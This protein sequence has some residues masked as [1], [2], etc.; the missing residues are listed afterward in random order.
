MELCGVLGAQEDHK[1]AL[2]E[3]QELKAR[4]SQ[5]QEQLSAS[6]DAERETENDMRV[7]MRRQTAA[8]DYRSVFLKV[9][10]LKKC[11]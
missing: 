1:A 4:V 7:E 3:C 11:E 5:L 2:E 10:L 8:M 6:R 9:F